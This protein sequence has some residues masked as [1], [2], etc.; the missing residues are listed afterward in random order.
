MF[1]TIPKSEQGGFLK[2][3]GR[4]PKM[5]GDIKISETF[6]TLGSAASTQTIGIIGRVDSL[7]I[8]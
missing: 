1:V 5:F 8:A 4:R 6:K 7:L 2:R 3:V